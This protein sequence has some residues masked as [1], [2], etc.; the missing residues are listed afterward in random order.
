M[1]KTRVSKEQAYNALTSFHVQWD[2]VGKNE[3]VVWTSGYKSSAHYHIEL[4]LIQ[5]GMRMKSEQYDSTCGK[6]KAIYILN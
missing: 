1:N 5:A 2:R 3:I 6:T 4:F